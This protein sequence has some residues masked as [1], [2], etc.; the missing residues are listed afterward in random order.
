MAEYNIYLDESSEMHTELEFTHEA[1]RKST[2]KL[3][4]WLSDDNQMAIA[5]SENHPEL[6]LT[7]K[8]NRLYVEFEDVDG[9]EY[10][11]ELV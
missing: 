8:N 6:T 11:H 2:I 9:L 1:H 3:K 7:F 10:S 4:A 5:Y